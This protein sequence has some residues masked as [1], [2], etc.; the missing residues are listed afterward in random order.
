M[1][2][3]SSGACAKGQPKK[4]ATPPPSRS[5]N[6]QPKKAPAPKGKQGRPNVDGALTFGCGLSELKK[7]EAGSKFFTEA[8]K[9]VRR[10]WSNY[11]LDVG[12][13]IDREED[14][15][16]LQHLETIEKK[17]IISISVLSVLFKYGSSQTPT[18]E[19]FQ[20][21]R[22]FC[23]CAPEVESPFSVYVCD[24]MLRS[25][26]VAAWPANLFWSKI[27]DGML[28]DALADVNDEAARAAKQFEYAGLK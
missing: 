9:N 15:Q 23:S 20:E 6:P 2:P 21:Q 10:N 17:A 18:W 16:V 19:K 4:K 26:A 3:E 22:A 11:L 14:A 28:D 25:L 27:G 1:S 12:K 5:K 7:A 24:L 8:W 13:R